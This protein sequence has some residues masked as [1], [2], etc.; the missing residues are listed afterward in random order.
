MSQHVHVLL[1]ATQRHHLE[2]LIHRGNAPARVQT[3]A[4]ILL[5]ADRSQGQSHTHKQIAQSLLCGSIT[6]GNICRRYVHEGLESAL[7]EKPRPGKAPKI[8]GDIEARLV[9]LACSDP[10]DG[11]ARW[12]LK[13]LADKLVSL[14]LVDSISQVALYK[15]LKKTRLNRGR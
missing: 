5:L 10:P 1:N 15:R 7:S 13:L 12:T 11:Q 14:E 2:N 8:T 4:R 6:V 9:M 3:R